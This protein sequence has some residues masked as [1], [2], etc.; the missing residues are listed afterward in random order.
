MRHGIKTL[1]KILFVMLSSILS[2]TANGA[3]AVE[4]KAEVVADSDST[5]NIV[6]T[7]S[8]ADGYHFYSFA[9]EGGVNALEINAEGS[10]TVTSIGKPKAS[11]AP[12]AHY[13]EVLEAELSSWDKD[14]AFTIPFRF[15]ADNGYKVALKIRYQACKDKACVAPKKVELTVTGNGYVEDENVQESAVAEGEDGTVD[16]WAAVDTNETTSTQ[17]L[18]TLFLRVLLAFWAQQWLLTNLS[19]AVSSQQLTHSS[20]KQSMV[21]QLCAALTWKVHSSTKQKKVLRQKNIS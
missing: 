17:S 3:D 12:V 21:R 5:G 6:V 11:I 10:E 16:T 15:T 7:A 2:L 1:S 14:V 20:T 13:E 9:P 4:W 18:N 19:S 8:V